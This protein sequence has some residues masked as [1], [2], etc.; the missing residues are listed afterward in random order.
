MNKKDN[1]ITQTYPLTNMKC[2]IIIVITSKLYKNYNT[3]KGKH[4]PEMTMNIRI[5]QTYIH[6]S[7][8]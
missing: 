2:N 8:N 1:T 7:F 4:I 3:Y 6:I 5:H